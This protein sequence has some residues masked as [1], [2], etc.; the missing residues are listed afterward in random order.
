MSAAA[1]C[2]LPLLAISADLDPSRLAKVTVKEPGE[3]RTL[4]VG[5]PVAAIE[6]TTTQITY[7]RSLPAMIESGIEFFFLTHDLSKS[8]AIAYGLLDFEIVTSGKVWM[9]I[10]SRFRDSG[11]SSGDWIPELTTEAQLGQS[12]WRLIS[13]D[14]VVETGHE[15]FGSGNSAANWLLFERECR[16]GEKFSIRTEKYQAPVLLRRISSATQVGLTIK[17][18]RETTRWVTLKAKGPPGDYDIESSPD[19]RNWTILGQAAVSS[20]TVENVIAYRSTDSD[21][22]FFRLAKTQT[23]VAT[24]PKPPTPIATPPPE[25]EI[26]ALSLGGVTFRITLEDGSQ[27]WW[28]SNPEGSKYLLFPG[29]GI[30]GSSGVYSYVK[31][32][33]NRG[34]L[35]VDDYWNPIATGTVIFDSADSG[36]ISIHGLLTGAFTIVSRSATTQIAPQSVAGRTVRAAIIDGDGIQLSDIGGWSAAVNSSG[37]RYTLTA[38]GFRGDSTGILTYRRLTGVSSVLNMTDSLAGP[39]TGRVE[40]YSTEFGELKIEHEDGWQISVLRLD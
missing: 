25:P 32:S 2:V 6:T 28:I 37:N 18:L 39:L 19:F 5:D 20:D 7:W 4:R 24:I 15:K 23:P 40:W 27:L 22:Q 10:S 14:V 12:G 36:F 9:I 26:A 3:W 21:A 8:S 16:A 13:R 1:C 17:I 38:F 29:N 11:N 33:P 31:T 34:E 30:D 35:R